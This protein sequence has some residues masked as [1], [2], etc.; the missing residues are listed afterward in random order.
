MVVEIGQ[1]I[2]SASM[3]RIELAAQNI[4]NITTPGYKAYRSF[5]AVLGEGASHAN[6]VKSA[7]MDFST[8]KLQGTGNPCDLAIVGEGFFEVRSDNGVFYTR[9]G[10]FVRNSDGNL[11]TPD[12]LLV[13]SSDGDINLSQAAFKILADGTVIDGDEPVAK[14]KVVKFTDLNSLV[15][16]G[17]S[18]F[19]PGSAE[20]EDVQAPQIRQGMLETSNVSAA[21][22]MVTIM[23]SLRS[24]ESGQRVVQ[25]YD[26]LMG[27]VISAFGQ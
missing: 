26:D 17:G 14:I 2:L 10:Q 21:S 25:V 3:Q 16:V 12:G 20:S 11:T 9:A 5:S 19:L 22:E 6:A 27:R 23:A 24:A 13:Q 4:A 8:G 7:A 18:L 1:A 15:P